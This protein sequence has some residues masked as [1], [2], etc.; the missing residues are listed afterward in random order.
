[1][2]PP[3]AARPGGSTL[4]SIVLVLLVACLALPVGFAAP[5]ILPPADE[6]LVEGHTVYARLEMGHVAPLQAAAVA[7]APTEAPAGADERFAPTRGGGGVRWFNDQDLV[8]APAGGLAAV[9]VLVRE[10]LPDGR[11]RAPCTGAVLAT[12]WGAP[13]PRNVMSDPSSVTYVASFHVTDPNDRWWNV[14]LWLLGSGEPVWAV[15]VGSEWGRDVPDD[16]DSHCPAQG[17]ASPAAAVGEN[18]LAYPGRV[19]PLPVPLPDRVQENPFRYNALLVLPTRPLADVAAGAP[20]DHAAGAGDLHRDHT[21]CHEQKCPGG[22]E[23][24]E[25]NSHAFRLL[26]AEASTREPRHGGSADCRGDATA[27]AA[28]H[29]TAAVSLYYGTAPQPLVRQYI[30]FDFDGSLSAW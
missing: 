24:R 2:S 22:D 10:T 11:H 14:D 23:M 3:G 15:A 13:D 30:L 20:R 12:P 4:R 25:G 6:T 19:A 28:C 21:A 9:A 27:D 1:M 16:G 18:G 17:E 29:G 26:P 5:I 7:A 8:A